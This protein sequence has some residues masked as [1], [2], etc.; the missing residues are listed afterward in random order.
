MKN[1]SLVGLLAVLSFASVVACGGAAEETPDSA[2]QNLSGS[3]G[4]PAPAP[5]PLNA[6][7]PLRSSI[8]PGGA[9]PASLYCVDLGYQAKDEA[10]IFPDGTQ[11]EQWAFWRG[12]CGG[13][14]SFCARQGGTIAAVTDTS[15]GW[16]AVYAV[17]T[18]PDGRACKNTEFAATCRCE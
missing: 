15:A 4:K 2:N 10:C 7:T 1:V 14:H 13:A 17:C 11:C 5:G 8:G 12:E 3:S 16:T 6:C 9:N 18:L